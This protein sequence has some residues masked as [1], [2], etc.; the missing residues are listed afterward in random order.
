[1]DSA[2][3]SPEA[4][5]LLGAMAAS[6]W[7]FVPLP[8][9]ESLTADSGIS[10]VMMSFCREDLSGS[11]SPRH[12]WPCPLLP[13]SLSLPSLSLSPFLFS[14]LL[15]SS[16][17][18]HAVAHCVS[19]LSLPLCEMGPFRS[20]LLSGF[21]GPLS[22]PGLGWSV[23][24]WPAFMWHLTLSCSLS[25]EPKPRPSQATGLEMPAW[26][27]GDLE[28]MPRGST[29]LFP[30]HTASHLRSGPSFQHALVI[31]PI[32]TTQCPIG[33]AQPCPALANAL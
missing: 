16:R 26:G 20:L 23:E 10:G 19:S 7:D 11:L 9:S 1:M 6:S 8:D 17:I 14:P 27:W 29:W 13:F 24:S 15:A 31:L 18:L 4:V 32:N 2:V 3:T 12:P 30:A 21:C 25:G 5:V 33:S 28:E 22:G